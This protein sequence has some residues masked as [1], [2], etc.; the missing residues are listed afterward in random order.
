LLGGPAAL[1]IRLERWV[2]VAW[3]GGLALLALVFGVV[4]RFAAAGNVGVQ[5]P[6]QVVGR[7]GGHQAGAAAAWMGYEFLWIAALAAF[8]AAAQISGA[9][10]EEADGYLDNL[11]ARP[12]SR[13]TWLAGRLGFAPCSTIAAGRAITATRADRHPFTAAIR[14]ATRP[15][16]KVL[17][18]LRSAQS[19]CTGRAAVR[20]R[21]W[22]LT[23]SRVFALLRV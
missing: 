18:G 21:H 4:A 22:H 3:A 20:R 11:L 14:R 16:L 5:M 1:V 15:R 2:A 9:R 7:L 10:G 13:G 6:E 17:P 23:S 19:P 12:V 8:A